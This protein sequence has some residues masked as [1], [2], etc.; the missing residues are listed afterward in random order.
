MWDQRPTSQ[1]RS[2]SATHLLWSVFLVIF[3]SGGLFFG[4]LFYSSVRDI[5]AYADL[6][7]FFGGPL[8]PVH[9]GAPDEPQPAA[10][11]LPP[12]QVNVLLVGIDRREGEQ[13]PWR[14]DTM[15]LFSLDPISKTASMLSIPRDLW[16]P[17][18]GY[19]MQDRINTAAVWGEM[20][21]YPG[22]GLAYA[23]R[24]VQYNLGVPVDYYV[25]IDFAAF[26]KAIDA[27]GG[28]DV[29]VPEEIVDPEYPT[30][31]GGTMRLVIKAGRQH[32]NGDLA[33][34]YVRTRHTTKGGDIGRARRQQQV[35]MAV[36][37]KA[38]SLN[39]PLNRLPG[40]IQTLGEGVQTDL[41]INQILSIARAAQQVQTQ[42]IRHGV[43]DETM[44]VDW[45]T[46]DG[47]MVLLPQRDKIR[48][49]V[50][51]IFPV[52]TKPT[53]SVPLGN[54]DQLAQEAARIEV[55]NGTTTTGLASQVASD[56]RSAGYNVVRFG[57]ADRF[58]YAQTVL[59]VYNEKRYTLDSL[60]DR[61]HLTDAQVSRQAA[62]S[63]DVDLR[64]ILGRNAVSQSPTPASPQ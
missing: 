46:P 34:K 19:N 26:Q 61:L 49:L 43:I 56:L 50:S 37:D 9:A 4:Y 59:I 13:G 1:G 48:R 3:V 36:R 63:A 64:I 52:R 8:N 54:P 18:P 39:Y 57:N 51:E 17:L 44:V 2:A 33:L 53:A 30:P 7:F 27:I 32:M 20:F 25:R 22:G 15:I 42:D 60:K 16:V 38:L 55:Q 12:D 58:D 24:A 23:K 28:I 35:I 21:G 6:P 5:V 14:T 47:R 29:D 41:S 45:T 40:L 11:P 62:S 10:E 31:D